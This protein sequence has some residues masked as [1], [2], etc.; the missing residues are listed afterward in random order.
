MQD[1]ES[2]IR[3]FS[4]KIGKPLM[5]WDSCDC[6][7]FIK[8]IPSLRKNTF[9]KKKSYLYSHL[10]ENY[11]N[12]AND[13]IKLFESI[14]YSDID[15]EDKVEESYYF[16]FGELDETIE[17]H[18]SI[19]YGED[20]QEAH[21]HLKLLLILGWYGFPIEDS[22][23]IK[24]S[25]IDLDGNV[26][27]RGILTD[28]PQKLREEIIQLRDTKSFC[29][30]TTDGRHAKYNKKESEYLFRTTKTDVMTKE[31]A[32]V[33]IKNLN[34][35]EAFEITNKRIEFEKILT[36]GIF[37]RALLDE[38]ENGEVYRIAGND[39]LNVTD[40]DRAEKLFVVGGVL[41]STL[42][43]YDTF[44]KIAQRTT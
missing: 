36:S 12:S 10:R 23:S 14:Q 18:I 31:S 15:I 27:I 22:L 11:G 21:L 17:K 8:S 33:K 38:R 6:N 3:D 35:R 9:N 29:V 26:Y 7:N 19:V 43:L 25:D 16:S 40:R 39:R 41:T 24:N 37:Y 42:R 30:S 32:S 4:D 34:V 13:V 28:L 1:Y 5:K 44:K 20:N 2:I